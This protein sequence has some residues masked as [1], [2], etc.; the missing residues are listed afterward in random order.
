MLEI[1]TF[2]RIPLLQLGTNVTILL[3]FKVHLRI[4]TGNVTMVR[5]CPPE[6]FVMLKSPGTCHIVIQ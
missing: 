3:A 1:L 2:E 6:T 4:W 5:L